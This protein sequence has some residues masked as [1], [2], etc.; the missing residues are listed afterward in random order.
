MKLLVVDIETS[1]FVKHLDVIVEIGIALVDTETK[2]IKL[3]FD[4]LVKD[5][6][7]NYKKHKNAWIFKNSSLKPEDVESAE[8]IE[9][10]RDEI[11]ALFDKYQMTAYNKTFDIGFLSRAGFEMNSV[12]CLMVTAKKYSK[13]LTKSGGKKTPSVEEIYNQFFINENN[14]PVYVEEHRGGAD[15]IDEAKIL[16]HMVELKTRH[17]L[18][19]EAINK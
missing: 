18:I 12:K 8:S 11:Q 9:V 5:E 17:K 13:L 14:S 16:L 2:E 1:G 4:K 3:V 15:A 7:W 19:S 10:Y 6:V